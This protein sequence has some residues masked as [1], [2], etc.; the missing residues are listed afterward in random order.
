[1][2]YKNFKATEIIEEIGIELRKIRMEKNLTISHVAAE[3]TDSGLQ[4]SN[5]LLGRVE[6]GER[7]IDDNALNAICSYY[8][9]SP[10]AVIISASREH[11]RRIT[12][13][14]TDLGASQ[15]VS[16]SIHLIELYQN[17][18]AEGQREVAN[19]MRL[20]AYMDAFKK[21]Q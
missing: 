14:Q 3:L 21:K 7:R 13:S 20:M 6:N 12:E 4:I 5:T 15:T 2:A 1:M 10:S 17:L 8:D 18:N 16:E 19:L 11:I 9:V